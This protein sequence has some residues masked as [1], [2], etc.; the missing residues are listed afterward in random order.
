M[1][2]Y[3]YQ[4]QTIEELRAAFRKYCVKLHPDKGGAH[5]EFC[6]MK[7]QYEKIVKNCAAGEAGRANS[8]NRSAR[9]KWETEKEL[10]EM[11]EKMLK[12]YGVEIEICGSWL[13]IGGNTYPVHEQLK[14]LGAK[15]SGAKKLWYW[16]AT[17]GEGKMR[18]RYSMGKIRTKYGS[19]VLENNAEKTEQLAA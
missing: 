16:S 14:A 11:I 7:A 8:E 3:F 12:I 13:W 15:F 9:Y 19:V 6:A 4:N 2:T 1:K 5:E 18:G 10:A 17:M